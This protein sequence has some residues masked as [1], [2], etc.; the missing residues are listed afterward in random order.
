MKTNVHVD[1]FSSTG[2]G[3]VGGSAG[4]LY[5]G[6][7]LQRRILQLPTGRGVVTDNTNYPPLPDSLTPASARRGL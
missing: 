2:L 6:G 5:E 7:V 4:G 3:V 1:A